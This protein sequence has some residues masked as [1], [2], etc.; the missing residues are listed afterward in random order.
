MPKIDWE[1][2]EELEEEAFRERIQPKKKTKRKKKSYD[3]V[4][5]RQNKINK[6]HP[7]RS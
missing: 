1:E 5:K 4:N 2:W 6:K 7:N 3:E